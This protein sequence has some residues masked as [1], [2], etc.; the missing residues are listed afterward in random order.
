MK[1]SV[2]V[3]VTGHRLDGSYHEQTLSDVVKV[4]KAVQGEDWLPGDPQPYG[5]SEYTYL[6]GESG[7]Q[8]AEFWAN[9]MNI[10]ANPGDRGR[11]PNHSD[12]EIFERMEERYGHSNAWWATTSDY[13]VAG[14]LDRPM[15]EWLMDRLGMTASS[16]ETMGTL[17]GPLGPFV[18]PDIDYECDGDQLLIWSVRATPILDIKPKEGRWERV[19]EAIVRLHGDYEYP[20]AHNPKETA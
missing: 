2:I 16:T 8:P 10:A 13:Q 6:A 12:Q 3:S 18:V 19:K 7:D 15:F 17:G 5:D 4:L 11:Q 1:F 20:K 14:I 9:A